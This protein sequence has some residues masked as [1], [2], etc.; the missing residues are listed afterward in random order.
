MIV[1]EDVT[2]EAEKPQVSEDVHAKWQ[3]VV[4]MMAKTFGVP[5]GL[6]MRVHPSEIE[7]FVSSQTDGNPYEEGERAQLATGLYCETV[8]D[9]RAPL[10]VPDALK[11]SR[12]D[13]NPDIKLNMIYYLG[14]P[15]QWPDG[16]IF[17]TICVLDSKQ[18]D[19]A[20]AYKELME[21]FREMAQRDL[22]IL[23]KDAVL[24]R[25]TE[26]IEQFN[27]VLVG[28][29]MRILEMKKEVNALCRELGKEP[30]YPEI[31]Q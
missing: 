3:R 17:G 21:E 18:N 9:T 29:E 30:L 10:L 12:W 2:P 26:Q 11:D 15:L 31:W 13:H 4:N 27:E 1:T 19:A 23:V 24:R 28:R 6:I 14:F 5:A 8:M 7:V 20:T 25:N 16:D 22:N